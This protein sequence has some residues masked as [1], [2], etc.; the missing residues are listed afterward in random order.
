MNID[1]YIIV[2]CVGLLS[3]MLFSCEKNMKQTQKED[4]N[5]IPQPN[6]VKFKEG[7]FNISENTTLHITDDAKKLE[8]IKFATD[9]L[10]NT[11]SRFGIDIKTVDES[12]K[13]Q[14]V[15]SKGDFDNDEAYSIETIVSSDL[16][17]IK[18]KT[19]RGLF[20]AF[21]TLKQLL[22]VEIF[23]KGSE[24]KWDVPAIS[25]KDAPT[26]PYRG[27]H[28]DVG[29]HY[30]SIEFI[31]KYIDYIAMHK[32][33]TFHWHLTED[34]GWRI[35][36]KKYPKLTEVG[37][38]RD[39]TLIGHYSDK[40]HKFDG[41]RYGG[42][43][44][45][46]QIRQVV[47]YAQER[48]VTVIPEIEFPGHSTAAIAS[49][50]ELSCDGKKQKVA[51]KWG[52]FPKG[53]Y[54]TKEINFQF[55]EDVLSE[56]LELF[57][58][59]Y[60]HIG[61]DEAPK[62]QWNKCRHCKNLIYKEKLGDSYGLQSYFIKRIEK[63]LNQR[64]RNLIGWDEILEGGLAPN[65]TVMSWRGVKGGIEAAKQNHDVIMTP[66][67]HCYFDHYQGDKNKEPVAIGGNT[68]LKKVYSFEPIPSEL[69]QQQAKHI[70]GAQGNVWTEYMKDSKKVEY[71]VF[72]RISALSE[73]VW[74][75]KDKRDWADFLNRM[76]IQ[77]LRYDILG[78][79]Y[80][81]RN[82]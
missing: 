63:F 24:K 43:Y 26:F 47:K 62:D 68:T 22:P 4:I 57:P 45:Q 34:Q 8:N 42:F 25:L 46:D 13:N 77:Y 64:G 36:I 67:T 32:M 54:C 38:Y 56:V 31:K 69:N 60:I 37:A 11:F 35:E 66:G 17:L 6:S 52:V 39:E 81:R 12:L 14:I 59:K 33:N 20:Y 2:L 5:I 21:Q 1:K 51:T 27:M 41:K 79:N 50:P 9:Y 28:L 72:P 65:A 23:G 19:S 61:G 16:L 18:V 7:S 74:T 30:F 80:L 48:F 15:I 55:M 53:V 71:M 3:G 29:R 73:V 44:T 78:I 10:Y 82:N 40:P 76:E 49:Y 75:K 70:L 58:S